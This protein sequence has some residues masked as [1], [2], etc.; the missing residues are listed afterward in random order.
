MV[1]LICT[2]HLVI[3]FYIGGWGGGGGGGDGAGL[4]GGWFGRGRVMV[5]GNFSSGASKLIWMTIGQG[6]FVL[7]LREIVGLDIFSLVY[8][9]SFLSPSD[10]ETAT[11]RLKY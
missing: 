6:H 8:H 1:R 10:W 9:T 4:R 11:Y 7:S 2:F 3:V 5:L